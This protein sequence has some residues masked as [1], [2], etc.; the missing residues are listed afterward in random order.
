M[1][2]SL[3][4]VTA[5]AVIGTATAGSTA[6]D[7]TALA[8]LVMEGRDQAALAAVE[9][10]L[11]QTGE[12]PPQGLLYLRGRLLSRLGRE[13]E[14]SE[15]FVA[16]LSGEEG[17]GHDARLALA[18]SQLSLGHPEVA[19]GLVST[20]LS[21]S[22][23]ARLESR[24]VQLL[25]EGLAAGG[26]CRLLSAVSRAEVRG[27]TSS[28]SL[29]IAR[30]DCAARAGQLAEARGFLTALL[31][32]SIEDEPALEAAQRLLPGWR[33]LSRA[34]A[35]L[36]ARALQH[37]RL[38]DEALEIARPLVA[39]APR[40]SL[41]AN[42]V[43][44]LYLVGRSLFWQKRWLESVVAFGE[45][46][47]RSDRSSDQ[48]RALY[49]QGRAE[50][51]AGHPEAAFLSFARVVDLA[52]TSGWAGAALSSAMR[53]EWLAGRRERALAIRSRL[54]SRREWRDHASRA[55]LFVVVSLIE[56]GRADEASQLAR[57]LA[58]DV[59]GDY[60]RGRLAE[61][62]DRRA[63]AVRAYLAA[64][65]EDPFSPFGRAAGQRLA[66]ASLAAPS[67]AL[68]R[69][70]ARGDLSARARSVALLEALGRPRL[71]ATV[72]G[73]AMPLLAAQPLSLPWAELAPRPT[74]DW[75]LWSLSNAA[76]ELRL[77]QLGLWKEVSS[78]TVLERFPPTEPGLALAGSLGLRKVGAHHGSVRMAEI[79]A[80]R[81]GPRVPAPLLP[82]ALLSALY[83]RPWLATVRSEAVRRGV[84]PALL[85]AIVRE[86]SRFDARALSTASA[87]GLTQFVLPT[88]RRLGPAVARER[89]VA[90]DLY[91]PAFALA[92][93]AAYLAELRETLP[94]RAEEDAHLI[95]A[96]YNAGE[97]QA[98]LWRSYCVGGGRPE[99]LS[100]VGFAET[101][102]Y[103]ERVLRSRERYRADPLL[104]GPLRAVAD[105][106]A[107]ARPAGR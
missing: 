98:R 78:S 47:Q 28:R 19:A 75:P 90:E 82:Q 5:G 87:R 22:P 7:R 52:P 58:D 100:K 53:L 23:P 93:G 60:W 27:K 33:E 73:A 24:A 63:D 13:T 62:E 76:G 46:A 79:L 41:A 65:A 70:L 86:E 80:R 77:L 99:F 92:L 105:P 69:E 34:D 44:L 101:R 59:E 9:R 16:A 68:A 51:L 71:A 40:Q 55:T 21:N 31:R 2:G 67:E 74:A 56:E 17:L 97:P 38:F 104:R 11:E 54:A 88:A 102:A 8:T 36:L 10:G 43:E 32:A 91:D 45:L 106:P 39:A 89:V 25:R 20:L 15:T 84:E 61:L 83:P 96:A 18:E 94:A 30:A 95:V 26:D 42:E 12:P 72:R 35:I 4:A 37:H 3:L 81:A 64:L 29:E 103:L 57:G 85:L 107:G 49:Q 66:E 1:I 50:E 14:A 48:A 6:S